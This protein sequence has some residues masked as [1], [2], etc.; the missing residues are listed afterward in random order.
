M[1]KIV[2]IAIDTS[3]CEP[4]PHIGF[5]PYFVSRLNHSSNLSADEKIS[6][7]RGETGSKIEEGADVLDQ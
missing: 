6:C 5:L 2:E 3:L 1:K 7:K 4:P